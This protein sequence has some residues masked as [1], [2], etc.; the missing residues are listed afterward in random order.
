MKAI[1][2]DAVE[3]AVRE[4]DYND[5]LESA[6][7]M[8]RCDTIDVARVDD[9]NAMIIDDNGLLV[10]DSDDS[11]FICFPGG[12]RIAGSALIVGVSDE[13]GDTTPT[14]LTADFVGDAVR[15]ATLGELRAAGEDPKPEWKF[16][17]Y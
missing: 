12:Q 1:L 9:R 8:L 4:V 3:K 2:I 7:S 13:N 11:P 14:S 15:F 5:T 17:S 16:Y 10:H 6:Y